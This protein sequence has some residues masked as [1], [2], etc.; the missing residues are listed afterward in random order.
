MSIFCQDQNNIEHLAESNL[1]SADSEFIRKWVKAH[2]RM[3]YDI[4][5][6]LRD[7]M[8]TNNAFIGLCDFDIDNSPVL[9]IPHLKNLNLPHQTITIRGNNKEL[10]GHETGW[11]IIQG[12]NIILSDFKIIKDFSL[13]ICGVDAIELDNISACENVSFGNTSKISIIDKHTSFKNCTCNINPTVTIYFSSEDAFLQNFADFL[14]YYNKL[15]KA[16]QEKPLFQGEG[17]FYIGEDHRKICEYFHIGDI[18]PGKIIFR[19]PEL[20]ICLSYVLKSWI[21]S[22]KSTLQWDDQ[23]IENMYGGGYSIE[24]SQ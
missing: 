11:N 13:R 19:T 9:Y 7:G 5:F 16:Y 10:I 17:Y 24:I 20:N 23:L 22:V 2:M 6:S 21:D 1:V 4:D 14:P 18:T 3:G 12:E 8:L 15:K